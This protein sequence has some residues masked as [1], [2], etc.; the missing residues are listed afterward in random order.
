ME[1]GRRRLDAHKNLPV[2]GNH[3]PRRNPRRLRPVESPDLGARLGSEVRN[4]HAQRRRRMVVLPPAQDE[5]LLRRL[6]RLE[7]RVAAHT[8]D[9][10]KGLPYDNA[11]GVLEIPAGLLESRFFRN[12]HALLVPESH[13]RLLPLAGR[14]GV[15][16]RRLRSKGIFQ[17]EGLEG[18]KRLAAQLKFK[19]VV[20][21]R[22]RHR[23]ARTGSRARERVFAR[24]HRGRH[25][26]RPD[27]VGRLQERRAC[28]RPQDPRP[29]ESRAAEI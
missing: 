26:L 7:H 22:A 8:R 1:A 3:G 10:R 17:Q 11:R 15:R 29:P 23:Q 16:L 25:P 20:R 28:A 4:P 6:A 18:R 2:H 19:P 12:P 27:V 9:R 14:R 5:P 21:E 24:G 13:R